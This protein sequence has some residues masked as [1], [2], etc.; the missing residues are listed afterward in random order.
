M[1]TTGDGEESDRD[2]TKEFVPSWD[3]KTES[4]EVYKILLLYNVGFIKLAKLN[5]TY[6]LLISPNHPE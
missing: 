5:I 3:G 6:L 1:K 4:L 2:D